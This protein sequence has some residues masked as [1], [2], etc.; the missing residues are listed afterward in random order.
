MYE[1]VSD[2]LGLNYGID[3]RDKMLFIYTTSEIIERA[4]MINVNKGWCL[5]K[6]CPFIASF[7]PF[8][9]GF[10]ICKLMVHQATEHQG[11][12]WSFI[13]KLFDKE[14]DMHCQKSVIPLQILHEIFIIFYLHFFSHPESV[15]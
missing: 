6:L 5:Y 7:F 3:A 13:Y 12:I 4:P 14:I 1:K 9:L 11:M 2:S 8:K 15:K 10:L